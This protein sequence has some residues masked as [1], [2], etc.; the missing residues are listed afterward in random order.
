MNRLQALALMTA[1]RAL[2]SCKESLE[3]TGRLHQ[4]SQAYLA[5]LHVR[6]IFCQLTGFPMILSGSET[7]AARISQRQF[8]QEK[9]A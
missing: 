2:V 9:Q 7:M 8:D 4:A 3:E 6:Q 5:E 1:A